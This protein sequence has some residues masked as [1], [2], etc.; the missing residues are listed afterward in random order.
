MGEKTYLSLFGK[1]L[2]TNLDRSSND[3]LYKKLRGTCVLKS[4]IQSKVRRNC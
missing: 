4:K 2:G 3:H 1:G